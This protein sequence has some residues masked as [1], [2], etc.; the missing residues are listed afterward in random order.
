MNFASKIPVLRSFAR[1]YA[2]TKLKKNGA[3]AI[4]KTKPYQ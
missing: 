3:N 4:S 1:A 2:L